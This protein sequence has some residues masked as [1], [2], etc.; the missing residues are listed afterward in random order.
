MNGCFGKVIILLKQKVFRSE[1]YF[2]LNNADPTKIFSTGLSQ[3]PLIRLRGELMSYFFLSYSQR[4]GCVYQTS[5]LLQN[6]ES[7]KRGAQ[8]WQT[9]RANVRERSYLALMPKP[10]LGRSSTGQGGGGGG[11]HLHKKHSY[12][13]GQGRNQFSKL[14]VE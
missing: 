4:E 7:Y 3:G 5:P 2:L 14:C 6:I 11:L 9:G 12:S 13:Q 10:K 8:G 1:I